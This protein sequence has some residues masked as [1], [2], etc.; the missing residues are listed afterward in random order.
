GKDC[1]LN[2]VDRLTKQRHLIPCTTDIDARGTA[3]LFIEHVFKLHGLPST[4][5]SD[6]GPQFASAF[7]KRLCERLGIDPRL[8]TAFHPQTDGQTEVFNAVMEQFLRCFV[9]YHQDNWVSLLPLAE[10]SSNN[11]VSES[12]GVSPFFANYGYDPRMHFDVANPK[13]TTAD[14]DA[15]T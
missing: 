8:S 14:F 11:H 4:I 13:R 6:R 12:I 3:D 15:R 1:I 10:F 5:V 7:W 9:N 2:V